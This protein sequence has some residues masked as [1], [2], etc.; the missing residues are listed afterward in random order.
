MKKNILFIGG[1]TG[2]GYETIKLM[3]ENNNI[4]KVK[5]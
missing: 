4:Y 2:I 5:F 3:Q 1:S